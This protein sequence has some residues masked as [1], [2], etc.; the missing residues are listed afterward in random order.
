MKR[1]YFFCP[2]SG[3]YFISQVAQIAMILEA[4][5]GRQPDAYFGASGGNIASMIGLAY[6]INKESLL[7]IATR[8]SKDFFVK[9]LLQGKMKIFENPLFGI[10]C[11]EGIKKPGSGS[12][13]FFKNI[14]S[15]EKIISS[16]EVWTLIYNDTSSCGEITCTKIKDASIFSNYVNPE[17]LEKIGCGNVHYLDNNV[18][19]I[20]KVT[21]ASAT[22]PGIRERIKLWE[23]EYVD[24]GLCAA[25]PGSFF[26]ESIKEDFDLVY[27]RDN[28]SKLHYFYFTS[29]DLNNECSRQTY[30]KGKHNKS[31]EDQ[32]WL[33]NLKN[34][35]KVLPLSS[36]FSDKRCLFE[37]WIRT[38]GVKITDL[39]E[40]TYKNLDHNKLST[41]MTSLDDKH[42][43]IEVF[44]SEGSVNILDFNEEDLKDE[45]YKACDSFEIKVFFVV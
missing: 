33:I 42:Y 17:Y 29:V 30:I 21:L 39:E 3:G 22:L 2:I 6:S 11:Y 34:Q 12:D 35:I 40:I 7:K 36:I 28:T 38:L 19:M 16:P 32:H 18:D 31:G 37:N 9:D 15:E 5:K 8:V 13:E 43:F 14:L 44:S 4:R 10:N 1:E 25:T 41:V 20:A 45:F 26:C 23:N 27:S 24:G